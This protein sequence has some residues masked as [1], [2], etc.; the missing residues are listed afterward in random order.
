MFFED[1]RTSYGIIGS[2]KFKYEDGW[3]FTN[4]RKLKRKYDERLFELNH[5]KN[6][7]TEGEDNFVVEI[8][9][10]VILHKDDK[11]NIISY[12]KNFFDP[13]NADLH[14]QITDK[15]D[16]EFKCYEEFADFILK[17][18]EA[19]E[20]KFSLGQYKKIREKYDE[21]IKTDRAFKQLL[22][23]KIGVSTV[24]EFINARSKAIKAIKLDEDFSNVVISLTSIYNQNLNPL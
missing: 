7:S 2:K 13:I 16:I 24:N 5:Y 11:K 20:R 6:R 12:F 8:P 19:K 17:Q 23:K 9:Q 15:F 18:I 22:D 10:Y 3:V 14:K 1:R 21:F 4:E